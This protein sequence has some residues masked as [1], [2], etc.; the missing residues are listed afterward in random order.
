MAICD[1]ILLIFLFCL[2]Q[3]QHIQATAPPSQ[4][5]NLSTLMEHLGTT[6]Q[7][8]PKTSMAIGITCVVGVGSIA[9]IYTQKSSKHRNSSPSPYTPIDFHEEKSEPDTNKY[10]DEE[11]SKVNI[12]M[13]HHENQPEFE[14]HQ[15]YN[16]Y[17]SY[18]QLHPQKNR[19]FVIGLTAILGIGVLLITWIYTTYKKHYTTPS[20]TNKIS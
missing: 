18:D 10:Y 11:E 6:I 2:S 1:Y 3:G 7:T 14:A 15:A 4:H 5:T 8:H 9:W 20:T 16:D 13:A 12:S 19:N 17:N